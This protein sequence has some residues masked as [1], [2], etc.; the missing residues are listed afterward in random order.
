MP[1][2]HDLLDARLASLS[3][4]IGEDDA[5]ARLAHA[6]LSI[7]T[8]FSEWSRRDANDADGALAR[9]TQLL[10]T[11]TRST[12]ASYS[13]YGQVGSIR[14]W[15]L[16]LPDRMATDALT[17]AALAINASAACSSSNAH[18]SF[19]YSPWSLMDARI[20]SNG[21]LR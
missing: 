7:L 10:Q 14:A 11:D 17:A 9:V 6:S 3:S 4:L 15:Q 18:A 20:D 5:C 21:Y 1:P 16:L 19:Y 12:A 8:F 13:Q 2:I